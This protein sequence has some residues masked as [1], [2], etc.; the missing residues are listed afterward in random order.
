MFF[1]EK[2]N[3]HFLFFCTMDTI[4]IW[5]FYFQIKTT[6][7]EDISFCS[8]NLFFQECKPKTPKPKFKKIIFGQL[9]PDFAL[10]FYLQ[11]HLF[12]SSGRFQS[13]M[14]CQ[15][16]LYVRFFFSKFSQN[17][18]KIYAKTTILGSK[19]KTNFWLS[20]GYSHAHSTCIRFSNFD[21]Y[22]VSLIAKTNRKRFTKRKNQ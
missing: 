15:T 14:N 11:T 2:N 8:L 20:F 16:D 9:A 22:V 6:K 7:T 1:F 18:R 4:L 5:F 21:I 12:D 3:A 17:G 10:H 13:S 19:T